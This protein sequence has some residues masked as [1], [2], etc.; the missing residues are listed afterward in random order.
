[1]FPM[2]RPCWV[3]S[4][5]YILSARR[6]AIA[7]AFLVAT[8]CL[9]AIPGARSA[10]AADEVDVAV[11]AFAA[12]GAAV[13]VTVGKTE[14]ELVKS[15]VRCAADAAQSKSL[16]NCARDELIKRLPQEAQPLAGCLL[17]GESIPQCAQSVVVAKL[18]PEVK[19]LADCVLG[20]GKIEQ[21]VQTAIVSKLPPPA[22]PLASCFLPGAKVPQCAQSL[23]DAQLPPDAKP[24][25]DCLLGGR[26]T[27][28]QC[29][30]DEIVSRVPSPEAKSFAGCLVGNGTVQ[31]CAQTQINSMLPPEVQGLSQ[32][33]AQR[34][35]VV[36]CGK[37]FATDQPALRDAFATLERLKVDD[38]A[39]LTEA[40]GSIQN[41][42]RVVR[43]IREDQWDQVV[44]YGGTEVA[45]FAIK[46]VLEVVMP[47]G[48]VL[49]PVLA[50]VMDRIIQSRA[51][52][53][54]G[55]M[56]AVREGD[57]PKAAGVISSFIM[58]LPFE[59]ACGMFDVNLLQAI[60][61]R[62]VTEL[63]NRIREETCGRIQ[64]M[65]DTASGKGERFVGDEIQSG[66]DLLESVV[67]NPFS[68]P[69]EAYNFFVDSL[70]NLSRAIRKDSD[71]GSPQEFYLARTAKCVPRLAYLRLTNPT[72]AAQ[73]DTDLNGICR[74]HFDRCY[75][76]GSFDSLCNP[77]RRVFNDQV[78]NAVA[79]AQREL[80]NAAEAW[81][82][83]LN[84]YIAINS[85]KFCR[86]QNSVD[87]SE[88]GNQCLNELKRAHPI[89]DPMT[90]PD[91]GLASQ[92]SV[93]PHNDACLWAAQQ[94]DVMAVV[95]E[96]CDACMRDPTLGCNPT[97]WQGRPF[98]DLK[99]PRLAPPPPDIAAS[100]P[101]FAPP[102]EPLPAYIPI[103]PPRLA[104]PAPIEPPQPSTAMQPPLVLPQAP[105]TPCRDG[106]VRNALGGCGCPEGTTLRAGRC[107]HQVTDA[108]CPPD[109]PVGSP[110]NCCPRG[111]QFI[112]GACRPNQAQC[113]PGMVPKAG[114][115]CDCPAG[116]VLQGERCVQRAATQCPPDRPIGSP[117]NC[118]PNGTHVGPYGGCVQGRRGSGC[119]PG[120]SLNGEGRCVAMTTTA[121]CPP[122]RPVGTPPNCCPRGSRFIGGRCHR[123]FRPAPSQ[124]CPSGTVRDSTGF[125]G[126][127]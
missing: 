93:S 30:Q 107:V 31:S 118:C 39:R 50:P 103:K 7:R 70:G 97:R 88:F 44:T 120:T 37:Q 121:R 17:K 22:Q 40:P 63:R 94:V 27:V 10:H 8:L 105:T 123:L 33:I 99:P 13:G 87:L 18:P 100:P 67:K 109:R 35:D 45:K 116:T 28:A 51:D 75:D 15:V 56:R 55:M 77:V 64:R 60:E 47:A 91:C 1:M 14:K 73:V 84:W 102:T 112:N 81:Y 12:G 20:G 95:K 32:C 48:S 83:P 80:K 119:P 115:G 52:L 114:G 9:G 92:Q 23:I 29:A 19:P 54:G 98:I 26:K 96:M 49:V 57:I 113:R 5:L 76:S 43:G 65:I 11:E 59:A 61:P 82:R 66:K 89:S 104:P 68:L 3:G 41:I 126:P 101:R 108:A 34:A 78:N 53:I 4:L 16:L 124:S 24:L 25:A 106:M 79:A 72:Q 46:M 85:D 86:G 71:C 36:Q 38:A 110:P 62:Q 74:L 125:C 58:T 117:P 69:A 90:I 122:D 111:T 2:R 6:T 21:C 42:L 127:R